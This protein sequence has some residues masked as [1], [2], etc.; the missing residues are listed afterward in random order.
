MDY[1]REVDGLRALAVLPVIF[2]HAGFHTFRGGFVGVDVFF[3]ISGYLITGIITAELEAGK[4]SIVN[5]YERR[6][7]RILPALFLVMLCCLPFS[8]MWLL[9]QDLKNF[10]QSLVAVSAFA[11][12]VLFWRSSGYFETATE[13]KPLLHT[14]SLAVEEQYY[15]F[16]PVFLALSWRLGRRWV[17]M[18]LAMVF[19]ISIAIAQWG[20]AAQPEAAFYLL[21]ARGWELLIGAFV[22]FY[23]G[24]EGGKGLNQTVCEVG[25]LAGFA[26]VIY[27]VFA[28]DK[29]TP[30]PSVYTLA[31]TL[32]TALII[33]C[34]TDRTYAGR[35]LGHRI[36]VGVGLISY[37]AYLWHQ[38][39]LALAKH[40]SFE[41]PG[42]PL[43]GFLALASLL[44]AYVSWKYVECPFRDRKR[45][46]RK[47]IFAMAV[48][49][50]AFFA[51]VGLMGHMRKGFPE[52]SEAFAGFSSI[53]T[54]ADSRC[55]A[56]PG[57]TL[58]QLAAGDLCRE[59]AQV[60]PTMAIV[61]DS[62]AG[63]IFQ[64]VG[65]LGAERGFSSYA[66][67]D[68]YCAPLMNFRMSK[69]QPADC[70]ERLMRVMEGIRKAP[71]VKDVVLAAE[72]A[73]YTQGYRDD[74]YGNANS[75]ALASDRMGSAA[76]PAENKEVF[77]RTLIATIQHLR[78][79]K[80]NVVVVTP[81]PEF[82]LPVLKSVVKI[83]LFGLEPSL[84]PQV[85]MEEYRARNAEVL[86]VFERLTD[87][88]FV[89][90]TRYFCGGGVC[91]STDGMG[92][93]LFSDT[94]HVTQYGAM[95]IASAIVEAVPA[96]MDG[97]L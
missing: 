22:S 57:R 72:W 47:P 38:P 28:F 75:P 68:G 69:Y 92:R 29:H 46:Q 45:F 39:M 30:F 86:K 71:A 53:Q 21:P 59:G 97:G 17:L 32:G 93:P 82:H 77:E 79:A 48:V 55:H 96:R 15:V 67:S 4:F 31:P 88:R 54:L 80:K 42:K 84:V 19:A 49:G 41:T 16:F 43:L 44:M 40:R 23:L 51:A 73:T 3:V 50:S 10:S 36:F 35:L 70:Q 25:G 83:R 89:D 12:N 13:L 60:T 7:R 27:S 5:F 81:V 87:V 91:R 6:A 1:R 65:K 52:R 66:F 20:S 8:W 61:G 34:A 33:L 26:L 74:G 58:E 9:P 56:E 63:V 14:W 24:R 18:L 11:S 2:F 76:T 85:S 37:S 90:S 64:S 95:P 94:N 62:H 78:E